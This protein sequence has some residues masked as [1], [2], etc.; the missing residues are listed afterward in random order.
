MDSFSSFLPA[1]SEQRSLIETSLRGFLSHDDHAALGDEPRGDFAGLVSN[2]CRPALFANEVALSPLASA[3]RALQRRSGSFDLSI[4]LALPLDDLRDAADDLAPAGHLFPFRIDGLIGF[5]PGS[6]G[7][8]AID[9]GGELAVADATIRTAADDVQ[10]PVL[11]SCFTPRLSI[12]GADVVFPVLNEPSQNN[13]KRL[14]RRVDLYEAW[15]ESAE[16]DRCLDDCVQI[17]G[18]ARFVQSGR[19]EDYL[20]QVNNDVGDSGSVYLMRDASGSLRA[21]IQMC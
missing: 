2:L 11:A 6:I 3:Q 17:G 8:V 20:A 9:C 5:A 13:N 4:C 14:W 15:K 21:D 1:L 18:W 10:W 7:I 16:G 19:Q 12:P